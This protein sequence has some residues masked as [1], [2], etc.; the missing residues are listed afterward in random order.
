MH[1]ENQFTK[2]SEE[3][4]KKIFSG[5]VSKRNWYSGTRINTTQAWEI[6]NRFVKGELSMGRILEVLMECG[7]DIEVKKNS[8]S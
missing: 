6:K 2:M 7:Y 4:I 8:V 5:L 1:Y 3:E